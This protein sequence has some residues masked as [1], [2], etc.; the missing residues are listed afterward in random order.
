MELNIVGYFWNFLIYCM[1]ECKIYTF[2]M[3]Y[4]IMKKNAGFINLFC[5]MSLREVIEHGNTL[6]V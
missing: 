4:A 2:I 3:F 6:I 5:F 1:I